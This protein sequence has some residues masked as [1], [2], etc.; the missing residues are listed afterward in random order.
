MPAAT[1]CQQ[2]RTVRTPTTTWA[3]AMGEPGADGVGQRELPQRLGDVPR[4]QAVQPR[5]HGSARPAV[6][7]QRV[8]Q[9]A[10]PGV[11]GDPAEEDAQRE[12]HHAQVH[13][14]PGVVRV[15]RRVVAVPPGAPAAVEALLDL[16]RGLVRVLVEGRVVVLV[17]R[18]A[19]GA[20][21]GQQRPVGVAALGADERALQRLG[22]VVV[23]AVPAARVRDD[24]GVPGVGERLVGVAQAPVPY[25]LE[26]AVGA[27]VVGGGP[28][29]PHD[30]TAARGGRSR[31]HGGDDGDPRGVLGGTRMPC[32]PRRPDASRRAGEL[33]AEA[34]VVDDDLGR[35]A[36]HL[37]HAQRGSVV[38]SRRAGPRGCAGWCSGV[39][40]HLTE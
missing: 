39:H 10:H 17:V 35:I 6:E 38:E 36:R 1:R 21:R 18:A 33:H 9:L 22:V 15:A 28:A 8:A 27:G 34:G 5:D 7:V 29:A 13:P 40:T 4:V 20:H 32:D 23:P 30:G 37:H 12:Q 26:E 19:D 2:P 31:A 3:K 24:P 16:V 14:A 25:G 11:D